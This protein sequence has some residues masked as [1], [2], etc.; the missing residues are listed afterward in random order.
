MKY[1]S[2]GRTGLQ[3]SEIGLGGNTFGPPRLDKESSIACLRRAEE[4]GVNFIDTAAIYGEGHS[5]SFIGEALAGQRNR[6]IIATK[7][8]FWKMGP[9]ETPAS[10]VRRQC[11]ESLRKLR[12]E[13]IDLYQM[14]AHAPTLAM[15]DI[16][17][18]LSELVAEG[19]VRYVGA[20]NFSSWRHMQALETARHHGW[21]EFVSSQNHYNLLHRHV[22]L[23]TLPFCT[24]ENIAFLPY[25]PLAGG[26]L[27]DKYI[28][29][30]PAPPGTRGA[31]GSP[32]IKRSRTPRN[33]TTQDLLKHWAHAQGH[34]L[35]EL[36]FAWLLHSP[37]VASVIAGVSS[38][39]QV[40][41][42]VKSGTWM[43]SAEQR[44]EVEA[45]AAWDGSNEP[46]EMYITF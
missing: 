5:E 21:P 22:E 11:E 46:I 24:E 7:F 39:A 25:H 34:T 6:W 14:H 20:C 44:A 1:C 17:E 29:D 3:V 19:K 28:K 31:A 4:L 35:S 30:Q 18:V 33:E 41:A 26:F 37:Q 38:P 32:I 23:E 8:N 2:L 40:E 45:I 36:A 13:T 27:T 15:E 42:N 16:L 10:R 43:L 9:E 12:T